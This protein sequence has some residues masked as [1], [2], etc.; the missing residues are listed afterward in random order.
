LADAAA[1]DEAE[2]QRLRSSEQAAEAQQ[3]AA[4][5]QRQMQSCSSWKPR[6]IQGDLRSHAAALLR[7]ERLAA[8]HTALQPIMRRFQEV[9]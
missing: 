9:L 6:A 2:L 4:Q 3:A 7:A 1:R 8:L 5:L